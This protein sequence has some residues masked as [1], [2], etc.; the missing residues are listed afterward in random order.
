ME[1]RKII[2]RYVIKYDRDQD[3]MGCVTS[4]LTICFGFLLL[5]IAITEH[6]KIFNA[7]MLILMGIRAISVV[8]DR[9][10]ITDEDKKLLEIY[11]LDEDGIWDTDGMI[12]VRWKD[13]YQIYCAY[14]GWSVM[15]HNLYF[16]GPKSKEIFVIPDVNE[17]EG[18]VFTVEKVIKQF[19]EKYR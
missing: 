6:D 2:D 15:T 1:E 12:L 8:W 11:Y 5:T 14:E 3:E 17:F 10:R 18:G 9:L 16:Y 7:C 4:A 19:W 13:V